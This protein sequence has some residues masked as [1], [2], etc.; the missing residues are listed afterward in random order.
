MDQFN[1][2]GHERL[3]AFVVAREFLASAASLLRG[4]PRGESAIADQL[5]RAG[6]SALL[7]LC[8]AAGRRRGR[9]KAHQYEIARGSAAEC[10]AILTVLA[11]R[12]LASA[13]PLSRARG[14]VLRLVCMLTAL[15]RRARG[16]G[17]T[18]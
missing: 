11:V 1:G 14:L 5:R 18:G 10:G 15:A 3:A 4:L 13:E 2:F 6:D 17:A 16:D 12:G 7:N 8:E 9:E